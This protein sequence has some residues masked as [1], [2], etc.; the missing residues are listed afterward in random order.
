MSQLI[1]NLNT[2]KSIKSDIKSA[3]ENKGVDMT[4]VSFP[5][6]ASKIGEISGGGGVN[7]SGS[8]EISENGVYDVY[9]Y[10]SASV[11]VPQSV[12]GFTQKEITEGVQ[13]VNL[14]N[15]ASYVRPF[16]FEKDS[17]LQT[18]NLPNCTS[19]GENAFADCSNLTTVSLPECKTIGS[20]AF[21]GCRN[22]QNIN[23][24]NCLFL[25]GN[26]FSDTK[27]SEINLQF[28]NEIL[29]IKAYLNT[30]KF[31]HSHFGNETETSD[32]QL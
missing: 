6:Y 22:L 17:Y 26:V 9:S 31:K 16:V 11:N 30:P 14:S 29:L 20:D 1:D 25:S 5:D 21:S 8:L 28:G 18:V 27:I 7:P 2:I 19:V 15:S 3:I 24:E 32:L 10:A 23:I 4:G 12:T 13:I